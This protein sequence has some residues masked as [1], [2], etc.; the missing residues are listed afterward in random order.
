ML[1]LPGTPRLR[2]RE[3]ALDDLD[4]V[5]ALLADPE[6]MRYYPKLYSRDEAREWIERQRQRYAE[7]GHGLW[8]VLGRLTG[9]PM[10]QVGLLEQQ[11]NGRQESEV[12]YLVQRAFWRH[13]LATEA[14]RATRDWAFDL[15]GRERV[16]ALIRPE[17]GPSQGVARK[18]GMRVVEHCQ[19]GGRAHDVWA[20]TRAERDALQAAGAS[21]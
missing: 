16:V 12:G 14:A 15:L 21:S 1:Q 2:F 20:V 19:H 9:L 6:V 18:L 17:N 13:G 3:L 4:F 10:A 7:H 11:V 8:L 5:A